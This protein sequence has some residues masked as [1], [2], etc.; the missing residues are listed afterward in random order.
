VARWGTLEQIAKVEKPK[1]RHFRKPNPKANTNGSPR[2][3]T[4]VQ[5]GGKAKKGKLCE[6]GKKE[7][8]A[9]NLPQYDSKH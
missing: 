9:E 1:Q 8:G 6:I 4:T 5:G 7:E 2:K 3:T